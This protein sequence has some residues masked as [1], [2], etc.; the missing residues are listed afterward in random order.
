MRQNLGYFD[1]E[2]TDAEAVAI[3]KLVPWEKRC[4]VWGC[5]RALL[6]VCEVSSR[7]SA[8]QIDMHSRVQTPKSTY[9]HQHSLTPSPRCLPRRTKVFADPAEIP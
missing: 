1:V 4:V 2:L 3:S 5:V 9:T 8:S 6:P 7:H